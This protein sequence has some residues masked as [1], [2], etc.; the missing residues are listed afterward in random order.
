MEFNIEMYRPEHKSEILS[1]SLSAWRRVFDGIQLTMPTFAY[2]AFYPDG[3]ATRQVSDIER[4]LDGEADCV[5][6]AVA[7][8]GVIG[9]AA[10]K[11]HEE[12]K[13]G[14]IYMLAVDPEFQRGGVAT[15]LIEY[16][17]E[18]MRSQGLQ[19]IF[20]ETGDD[21]GHQPAR[22]L[23][24]ASGFEPWRAVRYFREL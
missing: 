4:V 2:S 9:W 21:P 6:V 19:V 23:Y 10:V 18:T 7:Q 15:A 8:N 14:E 1:L 5:S 17:V 16:S 22:A 13:M 3:W 12:I 11:T 24:E 20:I